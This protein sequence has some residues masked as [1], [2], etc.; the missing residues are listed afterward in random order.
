[1]HALIEELIGRG[2]VLTDGAWGTQLQARGL[3]IGEF[4]D[5]WNLSHPESVAAVAQAYVHAGSDIILTNTFGANRL[6]LADH[7]LADRTVEINRRGVE[8][9]QQAANGDALVFASIGP[10]GKM[11]LN[12]ET[13]IDALRKAFDEQARALADAGADGIVIETMS[14]LAEAQQAVIAARATG[15]PV[16]ACMVFDSGRNKDR[17]LMGAT[18]EEAA[19]VLSLAGA[20]VVGANC[21]QGIS[22][23]LPICQRLRA[24]TPL[25]I[26]I[27]PNAGLPEIRAGQVVFPTHPEGFAS[28]ARALIEAGAA[29]IGGCCGTDPDFIRALKK[30]VTQIERGQ[31]EVTI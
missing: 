1:M 27:K 19:L 2:P 23:F 13:T 21:G 15:L 22:G 10:S 29:F 11:L 6:R 12:E 20:D 4:P 3:A 17:T 24:A 5:V 25:P 18:P 8:I 26:W 16:V 14:D 31:Y 7:Q 9:S 30:E 28:H